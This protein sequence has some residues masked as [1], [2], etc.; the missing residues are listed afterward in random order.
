MAPW[1]ATKGLPSSLRQVSAGGGSPVAPQVSVTSD[2]SA[3]VA[4]PG[5]DAIRGG[6]GVNI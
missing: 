4:S 6:T 2:P 5:G 1:F 3:A